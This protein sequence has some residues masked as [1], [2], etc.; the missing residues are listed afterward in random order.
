MWQNKQVLLAKGG[1]RGFFEKKL[2][3]P[4]AKSKKICSLQKSEL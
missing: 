4:L 1:F 3:K 2:K